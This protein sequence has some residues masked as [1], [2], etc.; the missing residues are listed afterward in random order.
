MRRNPFND[1]PDESSSL[2]RHSTSS[3]SQ[4]SPPSI[5]DSV[6]NRQTPAPRIPS[7]QEDDDGHRDGEPENGADT[8]ALVPGKATRNKSFELIQWFFIHFIF[9]AFRLELGSDAAGTATPESERNL[10]RDRIRCHLHPQ[11]L[12]H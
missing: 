12:C 2:L 1:D 6:D 4:L 5:Y 3:S 8:E 7:R 10:L 11:Q 9:V